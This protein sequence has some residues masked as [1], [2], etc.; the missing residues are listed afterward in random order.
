MAHIKTHCV[1]TCILQELEPRI[2]ETCSALMNRLEE[3]DK[4]IA[5]L[6]ARFEKDEVIISVTRYFTHL[7]EMEYSFLL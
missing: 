1:H 2:T 5:V 6:L 3:N 7:C 4:E